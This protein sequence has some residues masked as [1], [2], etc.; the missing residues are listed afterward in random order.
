MFV[1]DK[2]EV[3]A[4]GTRGYWASHGTRG[5]IYGQADN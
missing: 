2:H 5:P 4:N 1:M 3:N